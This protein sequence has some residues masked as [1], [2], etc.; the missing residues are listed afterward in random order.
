[1][2]IV[3]GFFFVVI[4]SILIKPIYPTELKY[5]NDNINIYSKFTGLLG[6]CCL[7]E[8]KE[9]RFLIFEKSLGEIQITNPINELEDEFILKGKTLEYKHRV[10]HFKESKEEVQFTIDTLKIN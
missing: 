3:T 4:F 5:K 10:C 7:Y 1:M 9:E 8:I 6:A 2:F